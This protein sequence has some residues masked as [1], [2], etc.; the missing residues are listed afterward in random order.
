M[1]QQWSDLERQA[2]QQSWTYSQFLLAL[3][4]YEQA[5]RYQTRIHRALNEAQLPPAKAL[6]NYDFAHCPS[7]NPATLIQ[8]AQDT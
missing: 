8:L 5:Q 6:S 4:E 7:L 1:L 3:C 2:L